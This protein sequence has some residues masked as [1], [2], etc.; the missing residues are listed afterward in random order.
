MDDD[1][2]IELAKHDAPRRMILASRTL[3]FLLG[4]AFAGAG[5]YRAAHCCDAPTSAVALLYLAAG[6]AL[7]IATA[8]LA[9][10]L[11]AAVVT[12]LAAEV[13]L[14]GCCALTAEIAI[15]AAIPATR[16]THD[17]VRDL[18][19]R[20][21]AAGKLGVPFDRR[22]ASQVV[23]ELRSA[24]VDAVPSL[25]RGWPLEPAARDEL[26]AG[27][28]PLSMPSRTEVV[29]C[30]EG[31][32]FLLFQT[33]E[34]GFNNPPGLVAEGRADV[35]VV[36]ESLALGY[37][38]QSGRSTVDLVRRTYP[39]TLNFAMAD[40]GPLATLASLREYVEPLEPPIV[41]W[42]ASEYYAELVYELSDS[43]LAR[44]FDPSFSQS[45]VRRQ[46]EVDDAIR[47]RALP[48]LAASAREAELELERAESRWLLRVLTLPQIRSSLSLLSSPSPDV[49]PPDLSLFERSLKLAQRTVARWGGR[50]IVVICPNYGDAVHGDD[51][52]RRQM[53]EITH[54]LGV[55]VV[56]GAAL[57]D[58]SDDPADLFALRI[59]SHPNERGHA[60][61]A[62]LI[63]EKLDAA[64]AVHSQSS[65]Q[66][67][68]ASPTNG[69]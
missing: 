43:V 34:F 35:A 20:A 65:A 59:R 24:G 28:Y 64:R 50:L 57:F 5:T 55:D 19:V 41:L 27:F 23:A 51:A 14:L 49:E 12:R 58:A 10:R 60:L 66:T 48:L 69:G 21:E 15:T 45:L 29:E 11:R 6:V 26:P 36:G 30:N 16:T 3:V 68:E 25:G 7:G 2:S 54:K 53:L 22:L 4:I 32:E 18:F 38:A 67:N 37:C 40:S 8:V 17:V 47:S 39:R 1:T 63:V 44:Y 42:F 61:L 62:E 9:L 52:T 56:D 33:D 46:S 31:G 13:A